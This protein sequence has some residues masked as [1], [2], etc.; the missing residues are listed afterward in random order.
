MRNI[1]ISEQLYNSFFEFD[2]LTAKSTQAAGCLFCTSHLNVSNY[3]R[4]PRAYDRPVLAFSFCCPSSNCR[5][6]H[7]P[8][9]IR[10]LG[11]KVYLA[12]FILSA[13]Q[14]AQK[15]GVDKRVCRQTF[16]RWQAWFQQIKAHNTFL[17]IIKSRFAD[18][19]GDLSLFLGDQNL[20]QSLKFILSA[21][22]GDH[23]F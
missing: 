17:K 3:H 11:R 18:W 15:H 2:F 7:S 4:K 9:S 20:N 16:S 1:H 12:F 5:K 13:L 23:I 22:K 21:I 6:R 8:S 10:F 14:N 19:D